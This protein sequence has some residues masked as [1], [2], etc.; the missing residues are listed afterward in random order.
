[1]SDCPRG[2]TPHRFPWALSYGATRHSKEQKGTGSLGKRNS[3]TPGALLGFL[4]QSLPNWASQMYHCFV[5]PLEKITQMRLVYARTKLVFAQ[6]K[7][8]RN[9]GWGE[10]STTCFHGYQD[11]SVLFSSQK[12]D[13]L[14]A[15]SSP[16][17]LCIYR[18]TIFGFLFILLMNYYSLSKNTFPRLCRCQEN[19]G[20]CS[21]A[22]FLI[23]LH[24]DAV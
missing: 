6:P 2:C 13:H 7:P 23:N 12:S 17:K 10:H 15:A 5:D 1:M 20:Y 16:L 11:L 24:Y 3:G 19:E 9:M 8:S 4:L 14:S 22:S 21:K 18:N